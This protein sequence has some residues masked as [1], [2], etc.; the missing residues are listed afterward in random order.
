MC[1]HFQELFTDDLRPH[2][3]SYIKFNAGIV[4]ANP[5]P[6][7]AGTGGGPVTLD[8]AALL[9]G[10]F[11]AMWNTFLNEVTW[12]SVADIAG[13][14]G[15]GDVTGF[16]FDYMVANNST[17]PLIFHLGTGMVAT[18]AISGGNNLTVPAQSTGSFRFIGY[19]EGFNNELKM[20]VSRIN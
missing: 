11:V 6:S 7:T 15:I 10:G 2:S 1:A 16:A 20:T 13:Q 4:Y 12:P 17:D 8:A 3:T 18:S 5:W 19:Y 14:L 9:A